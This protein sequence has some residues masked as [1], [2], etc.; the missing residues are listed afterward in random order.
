MWFCCYHSF[1]QKGTWPPFFLYMSVF[2]KIIERS[3]FDS[4]VHLKTFFFF[5]QIIIIMISLSWDSLIF[6]PFNKVS[7]KSCIYL[8]RSHSSLKTNITTLI[9]GNRVKIE[10]YTCICNNLYCLRVLYYKIVISTN[11]FA[12]FWLGSL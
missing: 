3:E 4:D 9:D 5:V 11:F 12:L 1:V 6:I 8:E 10:S 2:V 7:L